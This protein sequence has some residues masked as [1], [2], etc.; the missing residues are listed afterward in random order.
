MHRHRRYIAGAAK[1][2]VMD[3]FRA[4]MIEIR[5]WRDAATCSRLFGRDAPQVV[6][7]VVEP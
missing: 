4:A 5:R 3:V 2:A 1:P 6:A 7:M